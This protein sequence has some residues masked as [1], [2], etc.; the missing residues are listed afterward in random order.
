[1][2]KQLNGAEAD[3][4][5]LRILADLHRFAHQTGCMPGVDVINW[6]RSVGVGIHEGPGEIL[7]DQ[8]EIVDNG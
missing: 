5:Y 1:M 6:Y 2:D 7:R 4:E 8:S 3:K